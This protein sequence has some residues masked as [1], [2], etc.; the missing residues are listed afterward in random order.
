MNPRPD[1]RSTA[2]DCD[3]WHYFRCSSYLVARRQRRRHRSPSD[4]EPQPD[5]S[6]P[7]RPPDGSYFDVTLIDRSKGGDGTQ[8]WGPRSRSPTPTARW[9]ASTLPGPAGECT[10]RS[11][12]AGRSP[13]HRREGFARQRHARGS[14]SMT[15]TVIL[16]GRQLLQ[17][18]IGSARPRP[19]SGARSA[20]PGQRHD[21]RAAARARWPRPLAHLRHDRPHQLRPRGARHV[22]RDHRVPVAARGWV[23]VRRGRPDG[24]GPFRGVRLRQRQA[25]V[26]TAAQPRH[27]TDRDDDRQHRPRDLP[28]VHVPVLRRC[29]QPQFQ[30][31]RDPTTTVGDLDPSTSPKATFW[32]AVICVVVL[33]IVSIAVQPLVWARP[34]ELSPTIRRWPRPPA[35]TSTVSS[36]P[37]GSSALP[38]PGCRGSCGG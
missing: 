35:S 17:F 3:W 15:K 34:P 1:L 16:E 11:R 36:S 33:I 20:G 14:P 2:C 9:S 12:Q 19:R 31:G 29:E 24:G 7:Q 27:R 8:T 38:S 21:G 10:S 28:A 18:P 23:R 5:R 37:S 26:A 6:G 30:R 4:A 13:S 22:R 25:T 32:S